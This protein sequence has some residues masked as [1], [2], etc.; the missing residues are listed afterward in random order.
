MIQ[1]ITILSCLYNEEKALPLFYNQLK[2]VIANVDASKYSVSIL[3]LNNCSTDNS[4]NYLK[5]IA[6]KDPSVS[7]LTLA[8]N[9]GYQA[10]LLAGLNSTNSDLVFIVDSDGEDPPELLIDFLKLYEAGHN[11]VYG[12]RTQREEAGFMVWL[13]KLFYRILRFLSDSEIILDMAEYSL[14][15]KEV[16]KNILR[17]ANTYPFIRAE[18]AY[19]GFNP[20]GVKY[21]RRKRLAGKSKYNFFKMFIF[22]FAG[23]LTT[24]TFP[25]RISAYSLPFLLLFDVAAFIF[26]FISTASLILLN[27]ILL[28]IITTFVNLYIARIYKNAIGRPIFVIDYKNS[29]LS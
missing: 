12:E 3:F 25:M 20:A 27:L 26:G 18:L 24:S 13:R 23:I 4:L 9:F 11:I 28:I 6:A 29:K 22:G 10:S 15:N 17:N 8:R 19:V 1:K 16:L 2:E 5:E 14:F 21:K 7:Y